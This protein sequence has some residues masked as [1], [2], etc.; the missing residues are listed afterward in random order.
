VPVA[1]AKEL[2]ASMKGD[3]KDVIAYF[4]DEGI[5]GFWSD[6]NYWKRVQEFI[7]PLRD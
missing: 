2:V 7:R 4:Y 6:E 5:H 3:E 1:F